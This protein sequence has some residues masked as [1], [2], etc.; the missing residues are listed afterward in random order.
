MAD[1]YYEAIGG[2]PGLSASD[3]KRVNLFIL[4]KQILCLKIL[5]SENQPESTFQ[6]FTAVYTYIYLSISLS[7]CTYTVW[8][9]ESDFQVRIGGCLHLDVNKMF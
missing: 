8:H 9:G 6:A 1:R 5:S 2:R 4:L 7:L 3:M